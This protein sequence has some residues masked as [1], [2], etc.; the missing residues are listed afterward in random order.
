MAKERI[1]IMGGTFDPIHQGHIQIALAACSEAKLDR[2][3]VVPTGNPPHKQCVASPEDRWRMVCAA[4]AQESV[5]T[6]SR[7]EMDRSGVIYTVDTLE[8][9]AQEY[10]KAELCYIIGADMLMT[11]HQWRGFEQFKRLCTFLVC[12]RAWHYTPRQIH[13]ERRRLTGLGVSITMLTMEPMDASS[14]AIRDA[15]AAGLP[16]PALPAPVREYC[17]VKGLYGMTGRL[18]QAEDWLDKLFAALTVKRFA[19]TLAVAYT[20]R[21][22]ARANGLDPHKAEIAGLL[23]DCA[24]CL[25]L[26]DMQAISRDNSLTGD[27][28][29]MESG[30]LL[31]S[32][33]GAYLA[34]SHYGVTDPEI[35]RAISCHTTGKPFMSRLDMAVYLADKI[36]PTRAD[37]P[38]LNK[39]RLLAQLSL[40]KALLT[41]LEGTAKY[42]KKGGKALHPTTLETLE[43]LRTLPEIN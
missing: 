30:N 15:L 22:L 21:Q 31:H 8:L 38:L 26:K 16:T 2:V 41:S 1:G 39:V 42:V 43:W 23:H 37:Y 24:K 28:S 11:L 18:P 20:A 40:E 6:P 25:P 17:G 12:P 32:V 27:E 7:I 9:L 34:A 19:H 36:E 5:L 4:C 3:L 14:T 33:T 29:L 35:L 13:D 10:P